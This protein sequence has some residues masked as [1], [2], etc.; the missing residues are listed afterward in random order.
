MGKWADAKLID[1]LEL[2]CFLNNQPIYSSCKHV[3]STIQL[4]GGFDFLL[5]GQQLLK[6]SV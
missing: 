6:M 4:F 3:I 5:L 2:T 1:A